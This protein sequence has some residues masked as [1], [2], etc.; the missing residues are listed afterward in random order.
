MDA[1]ALVIGNNNYTHKRNKLN[2]AVNDANSIAETLL[3]LGYI[4]QKRNR[5]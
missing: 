2:N 5:L 3:R 4:V 1:L